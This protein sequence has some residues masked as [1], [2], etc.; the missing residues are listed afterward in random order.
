VFVGDGV[1]AMVG[2][3][4]MEVRVKPDQNPDFDVY[5]QSTS[6]NRKLVAGTKVMLLV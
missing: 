3:P 2:L 4:D 6:T 5:V 1:R